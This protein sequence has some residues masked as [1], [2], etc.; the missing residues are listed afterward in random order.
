MSVQNHAPKLRSFIA[1]SQAFAAGR[2]TPAAFLELCLTAY[3]ARDAEIKAFASVSLHDARAAAEASTVRWKAGKPLS[4]IDGMPI[5]VKDIIETIDM[6]TSMGSPLFEGWCSNRDAATVHALR[7]AGAVLVG[8]TVTTEF[9]ASPPA[10]TRNPHDLARTPGGSSSGSAAAV[11]AEM[12]AAALGTQ[13]VGSIIRPAGYCG[14]WG[15]K[16]TVGGLNRGG[17]YDYLSQSCVG[18]LAASRADTWQVAREIVARAGGDPGYHGIA[19]PDATPEVVAPRTLAFIETAGWEIASPDA[20][21]ALKHL[22]DNLAAADIKIIT[23]ETNEAVAALEQVMPEVLP[24]TRKI[25]AWEERWPLNTYARRDAS[26]LSASALA[27][28]RDGESMSIDDYR[29]ALARRDEIRAM[30][31]RLADVVD[32][33]ITLSA[34]DVAP[35][36]VETT[37]NPI[38]AV[39]ASLLGVP[40]LSLPL[41]TIGGLPL[42]VQLVGF[43]ARDADLFATAGAVEEI[44]FSPR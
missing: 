31:A 34:P 37:G 15:Y 12:V 41:L 29:A 8:K 7:E 4:P 24:L 22:L 39:P 23:R 6:P 40:A 28:L 9:A 42:G 33:H 3:G 10:A 20:K 44:A 14:C 38:F 32:A 17:S 11:G 2:D 19:G 43:S 25:I 35:V 5:G 27:R 30:H 13:V 1:A 18:V 36:G 26:K 21:P 16:P